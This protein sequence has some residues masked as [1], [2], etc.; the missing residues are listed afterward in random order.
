MLGHEQV[1]QL[2]GE[3]YSRFC[4]GDLYFPT[5]CGRLLLWDPCSDYM[6]VSSW[7]RDFN[8]FVSDPNTR[9][10]KTIPMNNIKI[11]YGAIYERTREY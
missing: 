11:H 10:E 5:K 7:G 3:V 8:K 1:Y 9:Y 4:T 2:T 6:A